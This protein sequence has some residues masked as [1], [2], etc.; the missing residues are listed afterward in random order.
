MA[1]LHRDN[2][3][4][5]F[6]AAFTLI[7]GRSR[8]QLK[9]TTATTNRTLAT[10]IALHYEDT[11]QGRVDVATAKAFFEKISDLRTRRIVAKVT[12]EL[13]VQATG[14]GLGGRT[15]REFLTDW[16]KKVRGEISIRSYDR[17]DHAVRRF[18]A[19]LG[20]RADV[21]IAEIGPEDIERWRDELREKIAATTVSVDRK[22]LRT[23]FQAAVVK[24]VIQQ[25]VV[26]LVKPPTPD[27]ATRRGFTKAE[28]GRLL[29]VAKG[30]MR[31]LILAGLYTGARLRDV[32][33]LRWGAVDLEQ[34]V[35]RFVTSKT[36][37][38]MEVPL[39]AGLREWLV[40]GAE[41]SDDPDAFVFPKAGAAVMRS[42]LKSVGA[43]SGAVYELLVEAGLAPPRSHQKEK[44]GKG[45]SGPRK[46][47]ALGFHSLRYSATSEL[48]RGSASEAVARD[49][50]GH[51]SAAVS[52]HYTS[53]GIAEKREAISRMPSIAD[54]LAAAEAEA[55]PKPKSA[56]VD[57]EKGAKKE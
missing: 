51:D 46:V 48:K 19:T 26:T 30:E 3:D 44:D 8:K 1:S 41:G 17:Y 50:V 20:P 10:R 23:A 5:H 52:R 38:A 16:L 4:A 24:R 28:L 45:R 6:R 37:R 39:A 25:N 14:R 43:V 42:K 7:S 34:N 21:G 15:T 13:M 36:E 2:R 40:E 33:L 47:S 9:R 53:V 22:V 57:A 27:A 55:K 54:L 32:C 35:L 29:A 11:S 18:L 31:G 56:K 12:D 49:L